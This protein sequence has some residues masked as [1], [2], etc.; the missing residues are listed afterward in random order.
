[1]RRCGTSLPRP[2]TSRSGACWRAPRTGARRRKVA[3]YASGGHYR[4]SNDIEA[5]ATMCA[6]AMGQG[7]R[8]FK[9]KIGG[10]PLTDDLKRIEAVLALLESG[11]TLAVDGNGTF[12]RER[13]SS[14]LEALAG[15]PLAWIEEPVHP[16]DFDLHRDIAARFGNAA[17]DRREPVL[18]R[19]CAKPSAPCRAA[20]GTATCCSSTSRSAMASSSICASSMNSS[21]YGWRRE[22]CA[23]HAGHLLAIQCGRRARPR[24]CGECAMD[25]ESTVR[26][27]DVGCR[28]ATA[29]ARSELAGNRL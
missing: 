15:Y 10:A 20:H 27:G 22:R 18:R 3:I 1:M 28:C 6:R 12:D 9:I 8:R 23:P 7:H 11:M 5:C 17:R 24:A 25:T 26:A 29:M 2:R 16:L 19:R 4:A 14:I 21:A 13:L